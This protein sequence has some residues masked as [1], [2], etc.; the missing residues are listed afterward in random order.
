MKK[1][2]LSIALMVAMALSV[3]NVGAF[4]AFADTKTSGDYTYTVSDGKATILGCDQTI[5][6]DITI[7]ET[8]GKATVTEIGSGAFNGCAS[9]KSVI[10]PDNIKKIGFDAFYGCSAL[11]SVT[12]GNGVTEVPECAFGGCYKLTTVVFGN[13]VKSI[14]KGAFEDCGSLQ[15]V[16]LP[17]SVT[18]ID[19]GAF[20]GNPDLKYVFYGGSKSEK[21]KIKITVGNDELSNATWHFNTADHT[22]KNSKCTV[23]G[24]KTTVKESVKKPKKV[25]SLKVKAGKKKMTVSWKKDSKAGGYE[26]KYATSKKFKK[27]KT[28]KIKSYKTAKKVIS[29]LKS[30]KTYY[31]KVRAFKKVG[32]KTYYGS[33]SSVKK[34]KVK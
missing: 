7:P 19:N 1:R 4:T 17:K 16:V 29:K 15:S 20:F 6:G 27:A 18:L 34:V 21:S 22:Y 12:I 30:K 28:V 33:Y 8:L 14:Y 2:L 32:G 9:L 11:A 25:S 26:I 13:K 24:A 23:C 5:S 10:I 3:I 31:V